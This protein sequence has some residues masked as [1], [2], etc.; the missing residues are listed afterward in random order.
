MTRSLITKPPTQKPITL[1]QK[2]TPPKKDSPQSR[3]SPSLATNQNS[4]SSAGPIPQPRSTPENQQYHN[5]RRGGSKI[6]RYTQLYMLAIIFLSKVPRLANASVNSTTT[7]SE[8]VNNT[9]NSTLAPITNHEISNDLK[10]IFGV[11]G[12]TLVLFYG[13]L[14]FKCYL[15][16]TNQPSPRR[17]T[18][19]EEHTFSTVASNQCSEGNTPSFD[20]SIQTTQTTEFNSF[21]TYE[22]TNN[23]L[24][25][26]LDSNHQ[27]IGLP[28]PPPYTP[29][30]PYT[31]PPTLYTPPPYPG[32]PP[33]Y[34]SSLRNT[35]PNNLG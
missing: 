6:T 14:I 4:S 12:A 16:P 35:I 22:E 7:S 28:S 13:F 24:P 8:T 32:P 26:S 20:T 34:E 1:N 21:P 33:S 19:T 31:H 5:N 15:T 10:L 27:A 2:K 30:P 25:L 17:N 23:V 18:P 29:L 3:H 9:T 11:I